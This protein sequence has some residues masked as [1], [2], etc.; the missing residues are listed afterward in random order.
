MVVTKLGRVLVVD[1]E[2]E[3]MT[4]LCET[5]N[6]REYEAFG[7]TSG[8]DALKALQEQDFDLLLTDLMMPGMNGIEL[9][10]EA[11]K[12]D[13]DMVAIMMTGQETVSTAVEAMKL[14]TFDF[15]LKP[16]KL[17]TLLAVLLRAMEMRRLRNE[18][19]QMC[20]SM[21][22]YDLAMAV[23]F[24][25]DIN[26]ILNK[27]ADAVLEQCE[28]DEMSIMLPTSTEKELYVAIAR[29]DHMERKLGQCIPIQGGIAGWVASNHETLILQGEIHDPRFAPIKPR[30]D[31][32][33]SI[34]TPL[35]VGGK[36][37]G[38][39]NV[40]SKK[41]KS[42]LF[43]KVTALKILAGTAASALENARLYGELQKAEQNYRSI[44]ENAT[45]GIF[46]AAT[47][48]RYLF[49]NPSMAR[50]L[51]YNQP[52]EV[53]AFSSN[54]N[55]ERLLEGEAERQGIEHQIYRR[56]GT[57][58]WVSE[59]VRAVR[60]QQGQTLYFEGTMED[61]T[62]RKEAEEALRESETRYR[63]IVETAT[64]G[65]WV[66]DGAGRTTFANKKMAEMLACTDE[67]LIGKSLH[68]FIDDEWIA[69][70]DNNIKCYQQGILAQHEFKFR[71]KDGKELW[72]I[73]SA[74]PLFELNGKYSGLLAM[75]TDIT[76]YKQIEKEMSRLDR[77]D[78]IG[79][80]A[81]G[82]GHEIRN[83]MTAVRGFLQL[84]KEKNEFAKHEEYFNLMI[85][86][87]DRANSIITE[88]LSL[89]KNKAVEL[90]PSKLNT[91]LESMFPLIEA[92]AI[93][94]D[95]YINLETQELPSLA[96]DEKEIRQL[97]LNLARNGLEAMPPGGKLDLRTFVVGKEVVLA[98]Q[99]QGKGI[100]PGVAEKIG[101]P[102]YTTKE[103]G[104][105]LGLAVCYKVAERHNAK[106]DFETGKT[107]TTFFVRFKLRDTADH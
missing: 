28:A 11:L 98:V 63:R 101:T 75:V 83:P 66:I 103:N 31:I 15:V 90:K 13:P 81:A 48:G 12:I 79:E 21:A 46:Q 54:R 44:F 104:T 20:E 65:I 91:I 30:P 72:V 82:I 105:G 33:S 49:V 102:F 29:G 71:R 86:E 85:S 107:G 26:V 67:E 34:S 8:A 4:V 78:L 88:F 52:E 77:L 76:E 10:K 25:L 100:E 69:E 2:V 106:I 74:N 58:I 43:G 22:I 24:S 97:I 51:G 53:A 55:Y 96:L 41:R 36:C 47:D 57:V 87:L 9:F 7:F 39:L 18:N 45:E 94:T 95:K 16:C 99:D 40:N 50:I 23:S 17:N 59:N 70:A 27:I 68:D 37:V 38:V 80:M 89:A 62:K 1:D 35:L 5:L 93:V 14:G 56:D 60:D 64:E 3:L 42:Y 92:D 84:F 61:I 73:L 19:L 6:E 32:R